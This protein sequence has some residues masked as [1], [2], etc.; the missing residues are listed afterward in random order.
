MKISKIVHQQ[1]E[2][3]THYIVNAWY[4]CLL[5][6]LLERNNTC[7]DNLCAYL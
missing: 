4:V 2:K 7:N 1:Y 3:E 5:C 6:Q